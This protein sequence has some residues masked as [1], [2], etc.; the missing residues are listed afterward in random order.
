MRR[1]LRVGNAALTALVV[2]PL[3]LAPLLAGDQVPQMAAAHAVP[4]SEAQAA[5]LSAAQQGLRFV[6]PTTDRLRALVDLEVAAP[7]G[8]TAVRFSVDDVQ[9]AELTDLYATRTQTEP[10]W[11]TATDVGWLRPGTH[12]VRAEADTPNGVVRVER[13]VMTS[14]EPPGK[15]ISP[16]TGGWRFASESELPDGDLAGATPPAVKPGY[17]DRDFATVMVPNSLGAVADR[18]NDWNGLLGVYRRVVKLDEPAAGEQTAIVLESCYWHCR[19]F[20]N[21]Q[22]VGETRGGYLPERLDITGAVVSGDNTVAVVVDHRLSTMGVFSRINE[23][24]WN[25]G[26]LLQEVRIERTPEVALVDL[27]A[28]GS[29][30]GTLTLRATGVNGTTAARAVDATVTVDGP[31]GARA[32]AP[33]P[34]TFEVPAG[35]GEAAPARLTVPEPDL[36]DADDPNLYTVRLEPVSTANTSALVER[37]GFRDVRVEGSDVLLNGNVV[38]NLQ[39]FNRHRD[40]PGLGRTQPDG[41]ARR[42]LG[43][44]RAKGFGIYRPAHYPAT[45]G[46]LDVADELGLLVIEEINVSGLSGPELDTSEVMAFGAD[47]L[48]RMIRRDRS[49]PSVI[50]W[51]VG[52]ENLTEDTRA[53]PYV[54]DTI[55]TGRALDPT[56]LY[57]QVSHRGDRDLTYDYQDLLT[58]NFYAGWY[59]NRAATELGSDPVESIGG[60]LDRV[61]AYGGGKPI[62]LSE[63]GAEAVKDRPGTGKGTEV[64]QGHVVDEH[65][66][67]LNDRPHL[68]G[69]MYWTSTEFWCR[70]DWSGG[71]PEPIPP[72][73]AKALRT[74]DRDDKLAWR[75]MFSP[76]RLTRTSVL[77]AP[78]G[79]Q[80]TLIARITVSDIKGRATSGRL[81]VDAPDGFTAEPAEQSFS[82]KAGGAATLDVRLRGTLA[83]GVESVGGLVRAVVDDDTE[84]QPRPLTVRRADV[85]PHPVGDSFDTATLDA[86][87][88][89]VREDP[90]GWSLDDRPGSL[91]LSTLAGDQTGAANDG[92]NLFLRDATPASDFTASADVTADLDADGQR[93]ALVAHAGDDDY[94]DVALASNEGEPSIEFTHEVGGQIENRAV[95]PVNTDADNATLRLVRRG[96]L[97]S[98]EYSTDGTVWY[99]VGAAELPGTVRVGLQASGGRSQPPPPVVSAYVDAL[100]V[101]VA[102]QVTVDRLDPVLP[103]IGTEPNTVGVTVSNSRAEPA[104]VTA[105]IGVPDGWSSGTV[106]A[107]IEPF[108]SA[109]IPVPV[110]PPLAPD[111]GVTLTAQVSAEGLQVYGSAGANVVTTPPATATALALD[112]GVAASPLVDGYDRLT[113]ADTWQPERGFGWVGDPPEAR[114][115]GESRWCGDDCDKPELDDLRRDF[116]LD[117]ITPTTLRLSV[118]AGVHQAYVLA[119]D[120]TSSAGD[121]IISDLNGTVLDQ[122]G[123]TQSAGEFTWLTFPVDGG[124]GGRDVDLV[125]SGAGGTYWRMN[126]LVLVPASTSGGGAGHE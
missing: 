36:W 27:R 92:R 105:S 72:F 123:G 32:L 59:T 60:L 6:S 111:V 81:V 9:L 7:T 83:E 115:R 17:R 109:E 77:E 73:H 89:I 13:E 96:D 98:A 70:P 55:A 126:A 43:Q 82:V 88:T 22:R 119:G 47:R 114:D 120:A 76:V 108:G 11:R 52:N 124:A 99:Q 68:L 62:L 19:V 118:P 5:S 56:R 29:A 95:V 25:W 64:Y 106:T 21:G 40:Y 39:G 103:M 107:T 54:R 18:Y 93:I 100:R 61:Q 3:V 63:Y 71:N 110:T 4:V 117:R 51:S 102:G 50:A 65:N 30:D 97:V 49:H 57:T 38:S 84:A 28:E 75:V 34:V 45:P 104:E 33:Q 1:L 42:E 53:V 24:Y 80:T 8:T 113:P 26:G 101:L 15:G 46:E 90:T 86:G 94:V 20:V 66:R 37:A 58:A 87:W 122:V 35:G 78:A 79:Q 74:L 67:L 2:T 23:F 48:T 31:D 44:L 69:K 12:V 112:A 10:V 116:A 121:T 41:L 14:W 16:L 91:R 125:I 85:V